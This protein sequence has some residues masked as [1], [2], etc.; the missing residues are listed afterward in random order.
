[1]VQDSPIIGNVQGLAGIVPPRLLMWQAL[2]SLA[3]DSKPGRHYF[4][5]TNQ[6]PMQ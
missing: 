6:Q 5:H 2:S 1:M 3:V 4:L